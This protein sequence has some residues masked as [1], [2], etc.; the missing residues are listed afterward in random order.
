VRN[1]QP[2]ENQ[3]VWTID[4]DICDAQDTVVIFYKVPPVPTDDVVAVAFGE[5]TPFDV[6]L[7]DVVPPGS[8][9][10]VLN[11][12]DEGTV[13]TDTEGFIY[14]PPINFVGSEVMTYQI[15]SEG[16][17]TVSATVRFDV[18]E[19]A[20]CKIPSIITPN[21][22]G[23][24]DQF[25]VPCL[26]DVQRFPNSLVII[27]NRWGDEVFRSQTPYQNNW[28]GTYNGEELPADTYFYVVDFGN[29]TEPESGYIVIQR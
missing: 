25:V 22:D 6:L 16:C 2:G 18:G 7:N 8:M 23:I 28:Q 24:N 11:G 13:A 1:L 21:G 9:A 20:A 14:T 12:P 10:S 4:D 26:L 27:F 19:G 3:F 15:Q 29:D 17:A 5:A